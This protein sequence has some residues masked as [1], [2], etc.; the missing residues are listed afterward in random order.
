MRRAGIGQLVTSEAMLRL[1]LEI[2]FALSPYASEVDRQAIEIREEGH[3]LFLD[4][5]IAAARS[6]IDDPG[7][8]ALSSSLN[9][10]DNHAR[11]R[12]S[13]TR[14][15]GYAGLLGH[16]GGDGV[17]P[18]PVRALIVKEVEG[19]GLGLIE[20]G[21]TSSEMDRANFFR[22]PVRL[23]I[24]NDLS[25]EAFDA[26]LSQLESIAQKN[27]S[28]LGVANISP[29]AIERIKH[30]SSKLSEKGLRLV[31]ASALL[32]REPRS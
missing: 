20:T 22:A 19:R 3:E 7:P 1:P 5:P 26:A 28:A 8:K 4:L 2:S 14:F 21:Q 11:L 9:E 27:G 6:P 24:E 10:Q 12:W 17:V 23:S 30:W 29:L 15:P 32:T 25:S 18:A 16:V 31:P 13:L